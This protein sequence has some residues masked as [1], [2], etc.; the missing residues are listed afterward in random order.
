MKLIDIEELQKKSI[1]YAKGVGEARAALLEKLGIRTLYDLLTYYP[2]DYEDRSLIKNIADLEHGETCSFEGT[3]VSNVSEARPRR[4]MF[5]SKV[6]IQDGTGKITAIWFNQQYV[7]NSLSVGVNYI[8][9]GK[10]D[11]KLNKPQIINPVF[12]RSDNKSLKKSLK[13]LPIYSLTKNLGQNVIRAI[14]QEALDSLSNIGL[15]DMLPDRIKEEHKLTDYFE[16]IKQIH[17]PESVVK[18]EAARFRL[19]FEELFLL[20]LGLLNYKILANTTSRGICFGKTPEMDQFVNSLPFALTGAQ[21]RVMEEVEKDMESPRVMNRLVQGDVGSGKTIIAVLALF[22]AVRSGY[23]GAFMV[24]TEILAEQHFKSVKPLFEKYNITVELLS[25]SQTKK[26]KQLIFEAIKAGDIDI[27][28]GT[29][30]L[31][32]ATVE[33]SRLGL[34]VTDEQHRFGVRQRAILAEKGENPDVLVMTATPIPRTLALILYGDLDISI[35]DELPP[36][37]K[38]IKTYAVNEAMRE[39]I[40]NFIREK[41]QEGRQVYIVCPLVEESEEI[42]AKSAVVTAEDISN[43]VFK[44]LSVGIIHGKMKSSEKEA[45]MKSFVSGEISILVSTTIIEVGVN[46]PNAT[47]MVIENAERFGLAQL[48]QL[49]G[50]VG[51]GAE[52]SYC[53]LFNQSKS[54]VSKERM[55]IMSQ[56]NDG[57]VISEKDLEIRGPGDFFGTKQHGLPELKIANLYKDIEVMKL[58]QENVK[59][60]LQ[61]DSNLEK[62]PGLKR[63]LDLYFGERA[64]LS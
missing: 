39:R 56:S 34:V 43:N 57:F 13:I 35:I 23:Q 27:V 53:V 45:I 55:K 51:R 28:I 49:R 1:R 17:Y 11:K 16:S 61:E 48:H 38:P 64:T 58:A 37:R 22:K 6:S 4:G 3:V 46:V 29:H 15:E 9:F 20:Q 60:L 59:A 24:P 10:I 44:D 14:I 36:G 41:V 42:E 21:K 33:F 54:Q 19:V 47:L 18:K 26:Q 62:S 12:E 2:K 52:Q 50:R 7:K 32:E 30:A 25:G 8:F 63:Y 5:I 31:I 40:N